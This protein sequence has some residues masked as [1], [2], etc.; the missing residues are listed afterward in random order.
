[1]SPPLFNPAF[2][3]GF[4]LPRSQVSLAASYFAV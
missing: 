2:R 4:L 1:V 3:R